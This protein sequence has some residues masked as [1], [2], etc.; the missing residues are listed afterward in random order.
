VAREVSRS[1]NRNHTGKIPG[2]GGI[3]SYDTGMGVGRAEDHDSKR[4]RRQ[5]VVGEATTPLEVTRILA[6]WQRLPD[7]STSLGCRVICHKSPPFEC[8][9]ERWGGCKCIVEHAGGVMPGVFRRYFIHRY[10]P[11]Q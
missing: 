1:V 7:N 6:P 9:Q 11:F 10:I 5:Q 3:E 2:C 4:T 8:G